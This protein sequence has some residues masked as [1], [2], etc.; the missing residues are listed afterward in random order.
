MLGHETCRN[1]GSWN[2]VRQCLLCYG[3]S[4][5]DT[6]NS[7]SG[8][9]TLNG[10]SHA[11]NQDFARQAL[12]ISQQL[13]VSERYVASLLQHVMTENPN[14]PMEQCIE[15]TVLEFHTR[16][17]HLADCMRY[18]F[19]AAELGESGNVPPFYVRLEMFVRQQLLPPPR[20]GGLSLAIKIF[21]EIHNLGNVLAKALAARQNARSNTVA[22]T[23]SE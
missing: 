3:G 5:T 21:Q 13:D 9:V 1:N 22:P 2:L 20:S 7:Q 4:S 23:Q 8:K 17:R 14:V 18:V 12:F 15:A 10:R 6:L 11:V 19:E 16:R